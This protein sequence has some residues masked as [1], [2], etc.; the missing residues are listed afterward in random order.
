MGLQEARPTRVGL[1]VGVEVIPILSVTPSDEHGPGER[2]PIHLRDFANLC[3][4]QP[5]PAELV[6]LGVASGGSVDI[7][8]T[9]KYGTSKITSSDK[10]K[11]T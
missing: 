4:P 2:T 3:A 8:I 9:A 10:Y 6:D 5:R 1:K 11:F 7:R